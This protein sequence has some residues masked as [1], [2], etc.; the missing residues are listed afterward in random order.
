MRKTQWLHDYLEGWDGHGMQKALWNNELHIYV[1]A[2]SKKDRNC[3]NLI[4]LG[5]TRKITCWGVYCINVAANRIKLIYWGFKGHR[6]V[7][8]YC[9]KVNSLLTSFGSAMWQDRPSALYLVYIFCVTHI[10]CSFGDD[11]VSVKRNLVYERK[12]NKFWFNWRQ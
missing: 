3:K 1:G 10:T 6:N 12:C 11:E 8:S 7:I 9:A 5:N 2:I 4:I